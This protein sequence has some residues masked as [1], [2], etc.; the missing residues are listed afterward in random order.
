MYRHGDIV[1][2]KKI[3]RCSVI[4]QEGELVS[5]KYKGVELAVNV[6]NVT[7]EYSNQDKSQLYEK[8]Y[9]ELP[10]IFQKESDT[11]SKQYHVDIISQTLATRLT[12][13]AIGY[14]SKLICGEECPDSSWPNA[15][16]TIVNETRKNPKLTSVRKDILEDLYK[17]IDEFVDMLEKSEPIAFGNVMQLRDELESGVRYSELL[18]TNTPS[19]FTGTVAQ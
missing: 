18:T 5:V 1:Q 10:V 4:T 7:L 19:P 6:K 8:V 17:A 13:S 15:I 2:V 9:R 16:N 12:T 3:G 14:F 11:Y